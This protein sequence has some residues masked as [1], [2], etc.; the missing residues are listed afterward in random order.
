MIFKKEESRENE[1]ASGRIR[2]EEE[3]KEAGGKRRLMILILLLLTTGVS[4]LIYLGKQVLPKIEEIT[5]PVVF[6]PSP[7]FSPSPTPAEKSKVKELEKILAG[8]RGIYGL[9]YLN[10][11]TGEVMALREKESFPA[12]SL[13]KL[14]LIYT[15]YQ[16]AREE[17]INLEEKYVLKEEDKVAGAGS[18]YQKEVG[19]VYTYR[20]LAHLCGKQS[21]N[22]AA[23]ILEKILGAEVIEKTINDLGM[24]NTSFA[25]R[26]T[27]PEDIA[28]FWQKLWQGDDLKEEYRE[29]ILDSLTDTI[30]EEQIPA[31]LPAGV[32]IAHKVGIDE[33]I[34]HDAGIIFEEPPFILVLMSK[35]NN[36]EEAQEAFILLTKAL[37]ENEDGEEK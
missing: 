31:A 11:G 19:V 28:I 13:I 15:L 34:L 26:Q 23:A 17:K 16:Q 8:R 6:R 2:F 24:R 32:R 20:D 1:I 35:D 37:L 10:L 22:T 7:A 3:E 4:F 29:E 18:L 27:T 14:P 12:A 25:R 5:Q 33:G 21:D 30:F 36:R 9:Y